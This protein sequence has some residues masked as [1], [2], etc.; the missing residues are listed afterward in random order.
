[1]LLFH[2]NLLV[3]ASDISPYSRNSR[4]HSATQIAQIAASIREFGFTNPLLIDEN[5]L[6]IAGHGR[7]EAAKYLGIPELPAVVLKGLSDAQ[8]QALR[9]ADNKIALNSGWDDAL[10]RTELMDLRA[11][12]FDLALTG[13]GEMETD[14]LFAPDT[15][16]ESEWGGMPEFEQGDKLAFQSIMVHFKD[17]AA[18]DA[19][20]QLIEQR[21]S[22]NTRFTWFPQIEIETYADKRYNTCDEPSVP[23]LYPLK[24]AR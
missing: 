8:K 22:R 11:A 9:I 7:L 14:Q 24:G 18:V 3:K 19:F 23:D 12:G 5:N 1:M 10:L 6:L 20:A 17:Q 2:P 13:F 4:T 15:D 21:I 16:A